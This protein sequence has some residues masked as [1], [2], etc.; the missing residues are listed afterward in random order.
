VTG[1]SSLEA[2]TREETPLFFPAGE[3]T[4]FGVLSAPP[5][6]GNGTAAVILPGGWYTTS[7]GRNRLLV[8]MARRLAGA[9]YHAF[10]F[11]FRGV[12]DSSGSIGAFRPDEPL[13]EDLEGALRCLEARGLSRFVLVGVCFGSRTALAGAA[14]I[15]GL[16]GLA[17]VSSPLGG[18]TRNQG[19]AGRSSAWKMLRRAARA[20]AVRGLSDPE[21]RGLY[22]R[23]VRLKARRI[24]RRIARRGPQLTEGAPLVSPG[25][26]D[27]LEGL[28]DRKVPVMLLYGKEDPSYAEFQRARAGPMDELLARAGSRAEVRVLSGP[29]RGFG[30]VDMQDRLL[31]AVVDW[32]RRIATPDQDRP[33]AE[34]H[35]SPSGN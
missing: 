5:A 4:L 16:A 18:G 34:D 13:E 35:S 14:G 15:P 32:G 26:L 33:G 8:R 21:L 6:G 23:A 1:G 25:F 11:D 27:A 30:R 19:L 12:G 17:L 3:N 29:L 22:A 28:V 31:D 10:R 20:D 2:S 9:G 24:T 7:T